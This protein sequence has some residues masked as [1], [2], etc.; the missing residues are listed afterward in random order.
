M[1]IPAKIAAL[2]A[3]IAAL[4]AELDDLGQEPGSGDQAPTTPADKPR[5]LT[6]EDGR[7]E[8]QRRWPRPTTST[9]S[10]ADQG[11]DHVPG[12]TTAADGRAEAARRHGRR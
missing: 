1:T 10:D 3:Q 11:D 6:A 8:A 7:R 2:Q 5:L 9:T 12:A 4:S